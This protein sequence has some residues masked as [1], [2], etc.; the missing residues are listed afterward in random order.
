MSDAATLSQIK[1]VV[2][3]LYGAGPVTVEKLGES[4]GTKTVREAKYLTLVLA[5]AAGHS[6]QSI[7]DGLG[8]SNKESVTAAL[9]TA[10]A[11]SQSEHLFKRRLDQA[12][13]ELHITLDPPA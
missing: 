10:R 4:G 8:Y 1:R 3:N 5:R 12:A 11:L 2:S 13:S 6:N 9:K 7:A